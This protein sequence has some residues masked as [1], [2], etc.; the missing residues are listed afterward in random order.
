[1]PPSPAR[2]P[3]RPEIAITR[4]AERYCSSTP[5]NAA[6]SGAAATTLRMPRAEDLAAYLGRDEPL[7]QS[8]FHRRIGRPGCPRHTEEQHC[9]RELSDEKQGAQQRSPEHRDRKSVV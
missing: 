1:M 8:G 2:M 4:G 6:P 3:A 9:E 7:Q 5:R